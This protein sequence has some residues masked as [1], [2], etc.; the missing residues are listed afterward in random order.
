MGNV[1]G[2]CCVNQPRDCSAACICP[3]WVGFIAAEAHPVC[4]RT[5]SKLQVK[6]NCSQ[7]N[8]GKSGNYGNFRRWRAFT[9]PHWLSHPWWHV[10]FYFGKMLGSVFSWN[11]CH[12]PRPAPSGWQDPHTSHRLVLTLELCWFIFSL[13]LLASFS[14]VRMWKDCHDHER[15]GILKYQLK[16][17]IKSKFPERSC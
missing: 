11:H 14:E 2:K 8:D 7:R 13:Q 6:V 16:E 9:S 10:P 12:S 5:T 1:N 17:Y 15:K 3:L 4:M